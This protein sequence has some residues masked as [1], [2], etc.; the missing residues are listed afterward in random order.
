MDYIYSFITTDE[1]KNETIS[2]PQEWSNPETQSIGDNWTVQ[3]KLY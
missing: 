3:S 1:I 2:K